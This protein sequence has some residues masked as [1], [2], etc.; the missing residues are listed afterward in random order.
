MS[1]VIWNLLKSIEQLNGEN[2]LDNDLK[3]VILFPDKFRNSNYLKFS[4][5]KSSILY[6]PVIER[7]KVRNCEKFVYVKSFN[8]EGD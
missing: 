7:S 2:N 5:D 6:N 3:L 4:F 8:S 1:F